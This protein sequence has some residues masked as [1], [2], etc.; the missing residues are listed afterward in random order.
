MQMSAGVNADFPAEPRQGLSPWSSAQAP[1]SAFPRRAQSASFQS[2]SPKWRHG[3]QVCRCLSAPS[4]RACPLHRRFPLRAAACLRCDA[5]AGWS[6]SSSMDARRIG[7]F[8]PSAR[9]AEMTFSC[10]FSSSFIRPP[11]LPRKVY[12]MRFHPIR[13]ILLPFAPNSCAPHISVTAVSS[14]TKGSSSAHR[15]R[16]QTR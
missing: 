12:Q 10:I 5:A 7:S 13:V 2:V 15:S 6:F 3:W 14:Y 11:R 4:L 8:M 16:V 9:S 1:S